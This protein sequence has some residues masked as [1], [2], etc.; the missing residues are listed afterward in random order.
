MKTFFVLAL[1]R[2][3]TAWMADFLSY[4][5]SF[6]FHEALS[7]YLPAELPKFFQSIDSE[8]VG[9]SD[10]LGAAFIEDL[11]KFF[12]GSKVVLI[13]RPVTEVIYSLRQ[14][15]IQEADNFM[16]FLD[17]KLNQI[18]REYA[19]LVADFHALDPRGIWEYLF[20]GV[21]LDER[22]MNQLREFNVQASLELTLIRGLNL[23]NRVQQKR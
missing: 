10:T 19:P 7:Q 4:D 15:G 21:P 16:Y 14:F 22:R 6:C 17:E 8:Y 3:M 1:P 11:L 18:E 12:P 5:R 2:S 9:I 23:I 20:P 13:R